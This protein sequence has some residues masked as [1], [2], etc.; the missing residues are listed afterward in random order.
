M[1]R[2]CTVCNH[3]KVDEIDR[4]LRIKNDIAKIA[5]EFALS[6]DALYRHA[7]A[8]HHIRDVTAI[9]SSSEFATS[10]AIYKEIEN[11]HAEAKDLQQ[12]AKEDGDIKTALL[13]LDKALKCLE[14]LAKI[15]GQI[16][17]QNITFNLQQNNILLDPEWVQLRTKILYALDPYPEAK[18]AVASAIHGK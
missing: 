13:G 18:E 5:Q 9:P 4:L 1:P 8:N 17:E 14:L 12:Q 16:R 15:N 11:W 2:T 6:Y 3:K 7:K 10:E